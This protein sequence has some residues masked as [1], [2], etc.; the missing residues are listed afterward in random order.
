MAPAAAIYGCRGPEL[1]SD[2]RVFF[3]EADPWGFILFARNVETPAQVRTLVAALRE[4]VGRDAPVL[5]DQEG[6]RVSR[7]RPPHWRNWPEALDEV[8]ALPDRARRAEAMRLRSRLIAGELQALGIDVNCAPLVDVLQRET[9]PFLA[10]RTYGEDP[11]EVAAIG[12][13][14]AEGLLAGG[15]LPIVKHIPGHGRARADSHEALPA[16]TA[17]RATLDRIDFAPFRA[18]ADLPLAMTAHVVYAALDPERPA[19][20]SPPAIAAIRDDI[21]FEGCLMTDD[22]SMK[23]LSGG[24]G[25]RVRRSLEAG[26]D[27]ILHCNGDMGEM[28]AIARETPR[29]AGAA[30]ERAAA[31]LDRRGRGDGDELAAVAAALDA[32]KRAA[33][34]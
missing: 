8:R 23:A 15:V 26:C 6:G 12:R 4:T 25:D 31:A 10:S 17:D 3:R 1:G 30:A 32:A 20:V 28:K 9:H 21:G 29:L 2:E 7:L 27:L 14:V 11:D 22:L 34:A 13:A 18:L 16:V 33:H 24:F 5:I 19:T